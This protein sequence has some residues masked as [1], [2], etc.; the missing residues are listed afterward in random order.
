[1]SANTDRAKRT[2]LKILLSAGAA[3][4]LPLSVS[5]PAAGEDLSG[6]LSFM[7]AENSP[8]TAPFWQEQVKAFEAAHP[9]VKIN[10]EVVGWQQMHDDA[11]HRCR[12]P[13]DLVNTATIWLRNGSR[14]ERSR[15]SARIT[16]PMP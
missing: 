2:S 15:R 13:A 16:S 7:V 10:L 4:A 8:K 12:Q 14:R 1:M 9:G 5:L 3:L 11:A 6:T